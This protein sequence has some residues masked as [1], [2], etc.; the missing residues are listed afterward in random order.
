MEPLRPEDREMLLA[1][2][3]AAPEDLD[4]YEELLASLFAEQPGIA[5]APEPLASA[6]REAREEELRVLYERIFSPRQGAR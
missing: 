1:Q 4:R 3:G 5:T 2:S 6:G